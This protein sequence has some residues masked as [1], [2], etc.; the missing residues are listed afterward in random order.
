VFLKVEESLAT[1]DS[2]RRAPD[3]PGKP[4]RLWTPPVR[5]PQPPAGKGRA[6]KAIAVFAVLAVTGAAIAVFVASRSGGRDLAVTLPRAGAVPIDYHITYRVTTG[7]AV[8]AEEL[9]VHRPFE[10]R[11]TNSVSNVVARLGRQLLHAAGGSPGVLDVAPGPTGVDVRFDAVAQDAIRSKLVVAKA[12]QSVAG[13]ACR[14]YRSAQSLQSADLTGPPKSSDY[15][16]TCIDAQGLVLSE[17][18]VSRGKVTRQRVA[19]SVMAGVVAP[20][21]P[22]PHPETTSR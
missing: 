18:V 16:D 21:E 13:R 10:A 17:R 2:P 4:D 12:T 9:S 1:A 11:D 22:L 8:D 7:K 14:V 5:T 3:E 15:V 19:V 6:T 20:T